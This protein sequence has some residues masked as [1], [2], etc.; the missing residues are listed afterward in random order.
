MG[1]I[2]FP[3]PFYYGVSL[4]SL[5]SVVSSPNTIQGESPAENGI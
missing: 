2:V 3:S 4:V 5:E 1:K